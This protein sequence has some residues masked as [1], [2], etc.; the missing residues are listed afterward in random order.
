VVHEELRADLR[1]RL[2]LVIG[3]MHLGEPLLRVLGCATAAGT[4]RK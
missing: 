4:L 1:R 2:A 3:Y